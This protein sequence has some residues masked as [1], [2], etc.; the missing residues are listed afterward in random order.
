VFIN[1]HDPQPLRMQIEHIRADEM[2]WEYVERGPEA[3]R[4]CV[5]RVALPANRIGAVSSGTADQPVMI[6]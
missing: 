1:D 6:N 3:F 4:V 2:K 5:T